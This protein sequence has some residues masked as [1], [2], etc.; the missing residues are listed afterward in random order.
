MVIIDPVDL[1]GVDLNL[2]VSL[3]VL[4]TQRHVTRSAEKLGVTQPA[5]SASLARSRTLFGD[6]LLVRGPGGLVLTPRGQQILDQL[7]QIMEVTERLIALPEEFMPEICHRTF[8]LMGSDFVECILLPSLMATLASEGP[9]LQILYKSPDRRNLE[10]MLANGELDLV[11]GYVPDPPK[12]LI[13]RT[14]FH[15]PFVC[16]ARRGHPLLQDQS[17]KVE[18]Y[19]ELQHVQ[20]LARDATMYGDDIERAIAAMGLVRKVALWQPTFLA[21]GHVV[22]QTNL[23]STVPRRIADHFAKVF[24]IVVYEPPLALPAPDITLYWHPRS[25]EDPG[26]KWLRGKIAALLKA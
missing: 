22:A 7:N 6:K 8:A 9:N 11:V 13:R 17:L 12:E 24:P 25:Q 14:L 19:V 21:V 20:V 10:A 16:V 1:R 5:M 4:L 2:L 3:R 23:I 15:E 18:H 26:H